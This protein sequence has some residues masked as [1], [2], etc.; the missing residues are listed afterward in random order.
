MSEDR[1]N[2]EVTGAVAGVTAAM[3][4]A[5]EAVEGAT[6]EMRGAFTALGETVE[7]V[8]AP[9]LAITIAF[10]AF[11]EIAETINKTVELAQELK[12]LSEKTGIAAEE[13]SALRY[14]AKQSEVDAETLSVSFQRLGRSMEAAAKTSHGPAFEAFR[15][16]GVSAK[17]SDGQ[18]RPF[19]AVLDDLA[20]RFATMPDGPRKAALAMDIF[21]RSGANMIPLL[22]RGK[23][24]IA[25]LEAE[26]RRLGVT[27]SA[28]DV[29]AALEFEEAMKKLKA[30]WDAFLRSIVV[31][32]FPILEKLVQLLTALVHAATAAYHAIA[33]MQSL[34]QLRFKDAKDHAEAW[35]AAIKAIGSDFTTRTPAQTEGAGNAPPVGETIS[36]MEKWAVAMAR[37][38]NQFVGGAG[39]NRSP[40][41]QAEVNFWKDAMSQVEKGSKDYLTAYMNWLNA[42]TAMRQFQFEQTQEQQR[43]E[44]DR[45]K[46]VFD[47]MQGS[48]KNAIDSMIRTGGHF[49]EFFRSLWYDMVAAAIEGE[50]KILLSHLASWLAKKNITR[51][52]VLESVAIET[53][54]ALKT[55]EIKV[56]EGLKWIAVEA[57]KAAAAAWSALAGIPVVGPLLAPAAALATLGAVLALASQ[58]KSAAGGFDVPSNANPI[59]QLHAE[60]MVLP[61][62]YANVIRGMAGGGSGGGGDTYYVNAMD[63]SSFESFMMRHKSVVYRTAF[64]GASSGVKLP[65]TPGRSPHA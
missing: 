40:L 38:R 27:M 22:N 53:W 41:L 30:V 23:D 49:R 15:D 2:V 58:I 19:R 12:V 44:S 37:L 25:E 9:L 20:N 65:A 31:D 55:V 61:K 46:S 34:W 7:S 14:A 39:A 57:A 18:L 50:S 3:K 4:E 17:T 6:A 10:K 21:G 16:L 63:A 62:E 1:V 28:D 13:L 36:Q 32:G 35:L 24:G 47:Q 59:T 33:G 54:G 26:A 45:W 64:A 56:W 29:S 52:G 5:A 51:A 11:Q 48:F 42:V 60:E 43:V 8:F